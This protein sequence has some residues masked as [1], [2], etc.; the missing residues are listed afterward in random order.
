MNFR[1]RVKEAKNPKTQANIYYAVPSNERK[2]VSLKEIAKEVSEDT[3]ITLTDCTVIM[4]TLMG[5]MKRHFLGGESVRLGLL[6]SFRTTLRS[7]S[8]PTAESFNVKY[9]RGVNIRFQPSATLTHKLLPQNPD[10][11][12]VRV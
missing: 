8:T 7:T 3:T 4:S 2:V 1:Y 9:I 11:N 12:F 6:G 10:L 5:V